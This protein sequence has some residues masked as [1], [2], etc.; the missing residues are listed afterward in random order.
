MRG[1]S[2]VTAGV[3]HIR[4]LQGDITG[5]NAERLFELL[6]EECDRVV[7]VQVHLNPS[8]DWS[9]GLQVGDHNAPGETLTVYKANG[10]TEI[11]IN[12]GFR[13]EHGGWAVDGFYLVKPGGMFQGVCCFGLLPVD[14]AAIFLNPAVRVVMVRI[15]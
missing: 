13:R 2:G 12:D 7:G 9:E 3:R 15:E 1:R 6:V 5:D 14:E 11:N 8:E 4:K 10:H